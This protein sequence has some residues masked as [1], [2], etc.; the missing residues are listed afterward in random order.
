LWVVV[1]RS[2]MVYK[3]VRKTQKLETERETG[4]IDRAEKK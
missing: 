4:I 2:M 3:K 1:K